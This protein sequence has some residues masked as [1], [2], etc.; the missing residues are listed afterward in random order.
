MPSDMDNSYGGYSTFRPQRNAEGDDERVA[1]G[2]QYG[3]LSDAAEATGNPGYKG[4]GTLIWYWKRG[5]SRDMTMGYDWLKEKGLLPT[6]QSLRKTHSLIGQIGETDKRKIFI[7]MQG[8]SWS[9]RGEA[10]NLISKS[11]SGHTSMSV[12][13]IA[14]LKGKLW[15]V[16]SFGWKEL[17]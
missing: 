4:R 3:Q 8:E 2:E 10:R 17:R 9:P 11:G 1:A 15:M 7:M 5:Q 13:D 12:G 16:D 14:M 6:T